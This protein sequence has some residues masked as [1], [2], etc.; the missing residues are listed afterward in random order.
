MKELIELLKE[1]TQIDGI[2]GHEQAV[3]HWFIESIKPFVKT[4]KMDALGNVYAYLNE[5]MEG[6]PTLMIE[7]HLDEVGFIVRHIQE[8]G[9]LQI[10]EVGGWFEQT[11][12]AKRCTITNRSGQQFKATICS[13]PPHLLTAEIRNKPFSIANMLVDAGFESKQAVLE[14]GIQIGDMCQ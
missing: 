11:L 13:V 10:K 6:K 8:N 9:L 3:A 12:L 1:A 14:A 4:I 5:T 7:G 2:S